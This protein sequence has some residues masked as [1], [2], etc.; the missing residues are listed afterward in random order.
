MKLSVAI[1]IFSVLFPCIYFKISYFKMA[2]TFSILMIMVTSVIVTAFIRINS[3]LRRNKVV[4]EEPI[5]V[6]SSR[7]Q[8]KRKRAEYERRV[9]SIFKAIL[10]YY[11]VCNVPAFVFIMITNLCSTC[12][13]NVIHWSR[14]FLQ[15]CILVNCCGNQF[16]YA[17]RMRSFMRA[18]KSLVNKSV[19]TE[20]SN[21]HHSD[22]HHSGKDE[23]T[24]EQIFNVLL[25]ITFHIWLIKGSDCEEISVK[26]SDRPGQYIYTNGTQK[27]E[28]V[29]DLS[30]WVTH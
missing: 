27:R 29:N 21:H 16:L 1:W 30:I 18:F 10:I 24:N 15:V 5:D 4:V 17:W 9:T 6:K 25:W 7:W 28:V 19:S 11:G 26:I 22:P 20:E 13:C 8:I 2:F 23:W 14:D 12:D 3:K